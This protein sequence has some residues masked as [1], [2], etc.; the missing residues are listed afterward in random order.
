MATIIPG[1]TPKFG[2]VRIAGDSLEQRGAQLQRN[3]LD[4][5]VHTE[6]EHPTTY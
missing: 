3:Y 5:L 6:V 2:Y 4:S 1:D